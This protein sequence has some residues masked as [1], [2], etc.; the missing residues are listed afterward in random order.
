MVPLESSPPPAPTHVRS[1]FCRENLLRWLLAFGCFAVVIFFFSPSWGAFVLWARVPEMSGM[2]E[3]RRG[4]SVLAQAA[5]PGA[6]IADPLHKVIQWRLLFPLIG[7]ALNLPPFALFGLAYVGCIAT[8]AHL[9]SIL[10]RNAFSWVNAGLAAIAIGAASW[11]FVSTGWLGYYDSWLALALLVVAF[12]ESHWSVWAACL[13]APW[14]D[15]RFVMALPVA[16]LCRWLYVRRNPP[17]GAAFNVKREVGVA[18]AL[19][20][21]FLLIRLGLLSAS[22][23]ASATLPGYF[24]GKNYLDAPI[25]RILLGVWEGLR[26]G[27]MFVIAAVV[28]LR[29]APRQAAL[30][31]VAVLVTLAV[32]LATAQDYSR[33]MTMLLPAAV[34]GLIYLPRIEAGRQVRLLGG[35]VAIALLLPAH[36]VMNDAVNPIFYLYHELA[37]FDSPPPAAMPELREL[38]AVEEIERGDYAAA[39]HD[40][41]LAI[42]LSPDPASPAKRRGMLYASA[43]RWE[44]AKAD[45]TTVIQN[46]P[47]NPDGWFLRAE[48]E[49][50]MHDLAAA[51]ADL[52]H[53]R[54]IAPADWANRPEVARFTSLLNGQ[55]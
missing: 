18:A 39:E 31:G 24:A 12:A 26:A 16:L 13:W 11:V 21:V 7:Y 1:I 55:H 46:E 19:I 45:F 20:A 6:E 2:L 53:A 4:I 17:T 28:L 54:A 43:R 23:A 40:L 8:L 44:Q 3:V 5:H 47:D 37:A 32:G 38:R 49:A 10:R 22:S 52:E 36:H 9:I 42:K 27:W 33:S 51:R 35:A 41:T 34:L 14:V 25:G 48:V 15:E 30:L 50:A 29:R